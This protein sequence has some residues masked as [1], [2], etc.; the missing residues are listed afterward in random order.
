MKQIM[1]WTVQLYLLLPTG[2]YMFYDILID[3][4]TMLVKFYKIFTYFQTSLVVCYTILVDL[5]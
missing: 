1:V 4:Y 3:F 2:G 5:S